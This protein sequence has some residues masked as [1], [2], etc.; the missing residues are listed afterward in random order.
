MNHQMTRYTG[1]VREGP[2]TGALFPQD[3]GASPSWYVDKLV[4]T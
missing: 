1:E 3:S 2:S 4:P